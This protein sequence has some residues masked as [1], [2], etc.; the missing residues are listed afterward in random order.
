M[1]IPHCVCDD[2]FLG[3]QNNNGPSAMSSSIL[4]ESF[5]RECRW[6]AS[7]V[8]ESMQCRCMHTGMRMELFFFLVA[9]CRRTWR[10]TSTRRRT[11]FKQSSGKQNLSLT[12][13]R[14]NNAFFHQSTIYSYMHSN[15]RLHKVGLNSPPHDIYTHIRTHPSWLLSYA[16]SAASPMHHLHLSYMHHPRLRSRV[17]IHQL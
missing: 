6:F 14:R 2:V 12:N 13:A 11:F 16:C 1:F 4:R 15:Y 8:F 17:R 10:L 7:M 9:K 3:A 5:F